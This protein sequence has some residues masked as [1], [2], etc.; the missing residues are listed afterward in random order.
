[1]SPGVWDK[2]IKPFYESLISKVEMEESAANVVLSKV[3]S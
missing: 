3:T 1:I 2:A